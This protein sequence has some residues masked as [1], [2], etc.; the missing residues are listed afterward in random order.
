M[1]GVFFI[2]ETNVI[3][4]CA[5]KD[6]VLCDTL[7]EILLFEKRLPKFRGEPTVEHKKENN[8]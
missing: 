3:R 6:F 4:M 2:L 1:L 8:K 7:E 5:K